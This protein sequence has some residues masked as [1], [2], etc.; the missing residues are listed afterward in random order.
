MVDKH[1]CKYC[2]KDIIE[3]IEQELIGE[4]SIPVKLRN[5]RFFD[6]IAFEKLLNSI[7]FAINFYKN[8]DKVPK[9]LALCF[10]DI[11]NYFFVD[12]KYFSENE[13]VEIEDA[14]MKL[15]ELANK[16]FEN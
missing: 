9:K 2:E 14:G 7:N 4:N 1:T 11:S 3:I 10:V 13:I 8:K 5:E 6:K 15:S 12:K 16:L